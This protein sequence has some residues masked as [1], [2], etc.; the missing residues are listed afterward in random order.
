MNT[1][2]DLTD[3]GNRVRQARLANKMSMQELADKVGYSSRTSVFQLEH[4]T[5]DVSLPMVYELARALHVTPAYLLSWDDSTSTTVD[6]DKLDHD[7]QQALKRY[8]EYLLSNE[9]YKEKE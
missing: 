2:A 4:G 9:K 6:I 3:F 8:A 5:Q 7:D 1:K